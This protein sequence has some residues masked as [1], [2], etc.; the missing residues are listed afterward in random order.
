MYPIQICYAFQMN[1]CYA[2]DCAWFMVMAAGDPGLLLA[3][4]CAWFMVIAVGRLMKIKKNGRVI[5]C[6]VH[7]YTHVKCCSRGG[8]AC[9][10]RYCILGRV[11]GGY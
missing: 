9:T 5:R 11:D 4:D 6:F 10:S 1:I 2:H 3:H 7:E 8:N